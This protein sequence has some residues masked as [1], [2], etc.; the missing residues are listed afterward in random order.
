MAAL[1]GH[2]QNVN[3]YRLLAV[4]PLPHA[5]S[6]DISVRQLQ[7][8]VSPGMQIADDLVDVWIWWF[9]FH[10]PKQGGVWVPH[11]GGAYTLIARPT[12]PRPAPSTGGREPAAP[13]T[14][15]NALNIPPYKGLADWESRTAPDRRRNLRDI[16][17]RY[18]PGQRRTAQ[19]P[20]DAK[21]TPAPFP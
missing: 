19:N 6:T 21:I 11:L 1:R 17:E 14:R 18:P 15:A 12:E 7:A 8:L 20:H 9:K 5:A 10:Q 4:V 13:Q 3:Q 16:V 2:L